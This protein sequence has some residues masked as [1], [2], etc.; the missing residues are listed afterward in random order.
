[1]STILSIGFY[2][3]ENLF[4][5]R[6]GHSKYSEELNNYG[7]VDWDQNKYQSKIDRLASVIKQMGD[8]DSNGPPAILGVCEVN[9]ENCLRDLCGSENLKPFDYHYCWK[10]TENKSGGQVALLYRKAFFN[11]KSVS[12]ITVAPKPTD[13]KPIRDLLLVKGLLC[14]RSLSLFVNHWPSKQSGNSR[15][16]TLRYRTFKQL[17]SSI[18]SIYEHNPEEKILLMGDFNEDL[19]H[20]KLPF[21]QN[22]AFFEPF[23]S[24]SPGRGSLRHKGKWLLLDQIFI[25]RLLY[26]SP[27]FHV[28][29]ARVFGP[30]ELIHQSGRHR[31]S[32]KRTFHGS[33]YVN[34]YSDHLPVIIDCE[35]HH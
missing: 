4:D 19:R 20:T 11:P 31:G 15:T 1:M 17:M 18:N 8:S 7:L 25:N 9:S 23:A 32:P 33:Y 14:G 26:N 21:N 16:T 35:I 30:D 12:M 13:Q 24:L 22:D 6:I 28:E 10:K 2:N 5:Y 3:L 27:W 34:G 29:N